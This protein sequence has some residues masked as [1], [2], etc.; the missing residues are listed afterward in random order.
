M[1]SRRAISRIR[2]ARR[3]Q[4]EDLPFPE[5]QLVALAPTGRAACGPERPQLCGRAVS[6][7]EGSEAL[8]RVARRACGRRRKR[9]A[10]RRLSTGEREP[11]ARRL[12]REVQGGERC[13]GALELLQRGPGIALGGGDAAGEQRTLGEKVVAGELAREHPQ[14]ARGRRSIVEVAR[15]ELDCPAQDERGAI[16]VVAGAP[17]EQRPRQ[18]EIPALQVEL[19]ERDERRRV[20]VEPGQ[21]VLGFLRAALAEA[22][23]GEH[24]QRQRPAAARDAG[25]RADST[26]R[27]A[28]PRLGPNRRRGRARPRRS[29]GTMTGPA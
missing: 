14:P 2:Q 24:R 27:G 4:S 5:R 3:D 22:Q 29:R 26:P 18:S 19:D 11:S 1:T 12:E 17:V 15:S 23:C 16:E 25:R 9:R 6:V 21:Q 7:R 13:N 8:E 28:R 10:D 20:V